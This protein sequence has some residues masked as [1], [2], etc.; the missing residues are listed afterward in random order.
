LFCFSKVSFQCMLPVVS[1]WQLLVIWGVISAHQWISA[2]LTGFT[3]AF[4][5][6][7]WFLA[8][9]FNRFLPCFTFQF[10]IHLLSHSVQN[11]GHNLYVDKFMFIFL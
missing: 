11:S 5:I 7:Q 1:Y 2:P 3:S 6:Q 9:T 10:N 4:S 8:Q